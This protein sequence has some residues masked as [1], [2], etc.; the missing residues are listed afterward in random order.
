[1]CHESRD[2]PEFEEN[3]PKKKL[4][5]TCCGLPAQAPNKHLSVERETVERFE[6]YTCI[7]R[8]AVPGCGVTPSA[9]RIGATRECKRAKGVLQCDRLPRDISGFHFGG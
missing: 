4:Q 8:I 5:L 3:T 9:A 7:L 1:M 2:L 6:I